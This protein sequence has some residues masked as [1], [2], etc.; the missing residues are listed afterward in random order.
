MEHD[1]CS[2]HQVQKKVFGCIKRQFP[3]LQQVE[4]FSKCC[5]GQ[6]ENFKNF[7]NLCHHKCDFGF[8]A[9]CSFF[10]TSHGK[11]SCDG[12]GGTLKCVTAQSSLHMRN[13]EQ[14]L[15]AERMF[16]FC[17]SEINEIHFIL[18]R[19]EEI[20]DVRKYLKLRY[21]MGSI[22]PGTRTYHCF[23]PISTHEI[24]FKRIYADAEFSGS[25]KLIA[26]I[27]RR[28]WKENVGSENNGFC[29]LRL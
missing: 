13:S 6:H 17:N 24:Q 9:T 25:F 8:E 5:T 27:N 23:T 16:D 10:A 3:N 21:T 29:C 22:V 15:S 12:I 26:F 4:Y 11:S 19:K 1:T 18:I 7:L 20:D 2:F 28:H 14:I